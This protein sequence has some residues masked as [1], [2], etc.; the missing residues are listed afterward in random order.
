MAGAGGFE[1][2]THGFGVAMGKF[3]TSRMLAFLEKFKLFES[4]SKKSKMIDAFLM[5]SLLFFQ[6]NCAMKSYS[7]YDHTSYNIFEINDH[8]RS[9]NAAAIAAND[10]KPW[11]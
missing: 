4:I 7:I 3:D 10:A 9:A 6:S 1:P 8:K 5:L 11:S 2:A